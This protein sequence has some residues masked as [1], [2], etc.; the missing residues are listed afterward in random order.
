MHLE[1]PENDINDCDYDSS[2][3]TDN[4]NEIIDC[5]KNIVDKVMNDIVYGSILH[6]K[7]NVYQVNSA[8][9]IK[10]PVIALNTDTGFSFEVIADTGAEVNIISDRVVKDLGLKIVKTTS[11]ANQ[12]D[13]M[14][15]NVIGMITMPV[16]HG[17]F[18]WVFNALVCSGVGDVCIG[19]NPLLCQG[20]TPLPSKRCI[21]LEANQE[22][23]KIPWRP[24]LLDNLQ[25]KNI[26][27][28]S[29]NIGLL[30]SDSS[31][32]IFPGES[33]QVKVPPT[34]SALGDVKIFISPRVSKA[35][36]A[37]IDDN[38]FEEALFPLPGFSHVIDG[39][40][41]LPNPSSFPVNVS[42]NQQLADIRI[43]SNT[44]AVN[45]TSVT[46]QFYP[47]PKP[48]IPENQCDKILL[49]PDNILSSEERKLFQNVIQK[50]QKSFTSKLGRYN[51]ELGNLDA[52]VVMNNNQIEPPSF[53]FRKVNQPEALN[54]KQQEVMD[55]MEADGILVRPEDVGIVP[56]HVHPS[57]MVPKM[58]DGNFTGEY[59]LVTGLSSLSPF[60][61]PV[62]VPL[63]TIE[64]AFRKL[65]KW[66]FI[67]MADLKSWHWQIP[68]SKD[69]MRFFG[70]ATPYGGLRIY[71]V[72]PM[73]Y[74]NSTE[75]ADLVIQSVLNPAIQKGKC[76]RIADNLFTGGSTVKEAV[77]NFH[78]LLNLCN[79]SGLTFKASKTVICPKSVTVLGKIWEQGTLKPSGHLMSTLSKVECPTT[80]KQMRSF[81]GSVKQMKDSLPNYHLLLHPLEKASA[82]L[83]SADRIVW[84]ESLREA[85]D[86]VKKAAVNPEILTL[87]KPGEK[88][89]IFP[90]WSDIHQAGAA[91]LYVRRS[92][93]ILKVRNFG[94]RLNTVKRWSPCEGES[95]IARIGVEAHSPWIWEALPA[96]TE[97]NCDNMPS[98]LA[99]RRLQR[100]EFSRSVRVTYF[101]SALA[102]FPVDVVYRKGADH[103]GDFD[104]RHPIT[105]ESKNCQVCE[106][107]FDLAGPTALE[108]IFSENTM[109]QVNSAT[110][111][112]ILSGQVPVPFS[113]SVGWKNIQQENPTLRKLKFH[114]EG[115]TIPKRRVRGQTELKRLYDLF[116]KN[117]ISLSREGVLVH[118]D[119]DCL[120]NVSETILVPSQIMRGL[121]L[122]LHNK[123]KCPTRS[124]LIKIMKRYWFSLG[125]VNVIGEVWQNC[126]RC[127]AA[128]NVPK[129]IFGQ[130]T[131]ATDILGKNWAG[132]VIRGDMQFIFCA[133]EKLSSF[134]VAKVIENE[135]QDTLRDAI[136]AVTAELIPHDG[137]TI[138]V[139]NATALQ[140]LQGDAELA[141]HGVAV[142]LGREKNKNSNPV[143]EKCVREYREEKKKIKPHGGHVTA[144]EL[145]IIIA[146]LNRRIRNRNLSA[147]EIITRRDQISNK[148]LN[149]DDE[150]LSAQQLQLRQDNHPVSAKSKA[151]TEK[152]ATEA[153][154]WPGALVVLKKDLTKLRTRETYIVVKMDE[155]D[156][157]CWIKKLESQCRSKNYKV[158]KN[159]L[160]LVPNQQDKVV[161]ESDK[162]GFADGEDDPQE[163][164]GDEFV[165][166]RKPLKERTSSKYLLRRKKRPDYKLMNEG[167][168]PLINIT[169]SEM[170]PPRYAWETISESSSGENMEEVKDIKDDEKNNENKTVDFLSP[171]RSLT[172][173]NYSSPPQFSGDSFT[174][175]DDVFLEH[176]AAAENNLEDE[177]ETVQGRH[178]PDRR[179]RRK[180]QRYPY[181]GIEDFV[182]W[183]FYEE[184]ANDNFE[185]KATEENIDNKVRTLTETSNLEEI[186]NKGEHSRKKRVILRDPS[187]IELPSSSVH[188]FNSVLNPTRPFLPELVQ[189]GQ[190]YLLDLALQQLH[191]QHQPEPDGPEV[192]DL[193]G[194]E[195]GDVED[196]G[197]EDAEEG[198]VRHIHDL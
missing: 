170:I 3:Y 69:S 113:Q 171:A 175:R 195:D 53:P 50:F 166:V 56:T 91:P 102:A 124:E 87:P 12:V 173:D 101:L 137:L 153:E 146:S 93:K 47:R 110:C 54:R 94:Q 130:S 163:E 106:F 49:D 58:D 2:I 186:I 158:K 125:M 131:V 74:L 70:T 73:G 72:Q 135:G 118:Q 141:R 179:S 25:S 15:L 14:P 31:C 157:F 20:I 119:H 7:S 178:N 111:E 112:D 19:G 188:N 27:Q 181:R 183:D 151:G 30:R 193:V 128:K 29:S 88:L 120:G 103:P 139:D 43:V 184:G 68:I 78:L 48:R 182:T 89:L 109:T 35:K 176:P 18:Y 121:V 143:A 42:K 104:S 38:R 129:E 161:L 133:R 67:I 1:V 84:T 81:T 99:A 198:A 21:E 150:N 149:L 75:N 66:Q 144:A 138:Q 26:V 44:A 172:W 13:K 6:L 154:V 17:Q 45:P 32:T 98:V 187:D 155:V 83:K 115:G 86:K 97:L 127:Q 62:R 107:A 95:W 197:E 122:A 61:K 96:R 33:L 65:A 5:N 55:A 71:A 126:P 4:E 39:H 180:R 11:G 142:D 148:S 57:F 34:I 145:A 40:V 123:F 167:P 105:C 60:L 85:F 196:R 24:E 76:V 36:I 160:E 10:A 59:R 41:M 37:F 80:V 117:K 189:T 63:P 108:S 165:R 169:R 190:C 156:D 140:A 147:R 164:N 22:K 114:M 9:I 92:G 82:G 46:E 100:G 8:A 77:E 152:L 64:E 174:V 159:E 23:V 168:S 79:N 52:K 51:G 194:K 134:T 191:T 162:E 16:T 90:D 132:D 136:I 116:T 177:Q 185:D 28:N 192:D